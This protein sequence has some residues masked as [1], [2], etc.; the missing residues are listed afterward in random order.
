MAKPHHNFTPRDWGQAF[1]GWDEGYPNQFLF[2]LD[3]GQNAIFFFI[4]LLAGKE[5]KIW[6]S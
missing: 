3:K 1:D 6:G 4:V 2:Y 5:K